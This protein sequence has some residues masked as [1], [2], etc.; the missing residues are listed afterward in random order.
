MIL[1]RL[2][3]FVEWPSRSTT[4]HARTE[5]TC[6]LRTSPTN[7]RAVGSAFALMDGEELTAHVRTTKLHHLTLIINTIIA[8]CTSIDSCPPLPSPD[9]ASEPIAASSC[10]IDSITPLPEESIRGKRISCYCG[11]DDSSTR[12]VCA[13]QK[14]TTWDITVFPSNSTYDWESGNAL[15]LVQVG[16]CLSIPPTLP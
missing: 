2:P 8:V 4:L 15:A 3:R 16:A 7:Q 13:Q 11:G 12:W 5:D 9:G 1:K 14:M 6:E 10:Q